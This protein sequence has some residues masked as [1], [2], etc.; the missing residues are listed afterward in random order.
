MLAFPVIF[1]ASKLYAL[2]LKI[3]M[4]D[5]IKLK[6][7]YKAK[8]IVNIMKRESRNGKKDLQ[9]LNYNKCISCD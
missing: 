9:T 7:F 3:E 5:Y 2:K 1:S 8:H 6:T 4:S